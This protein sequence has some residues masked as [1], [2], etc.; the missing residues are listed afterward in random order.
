MT[1]RDAFLGALA[2]AS[3]LALAPNQNAAQRAHQPPRPQA[4]RVSGGVQAQITVLPLH[5]GHNSVDLLGTG[6]PGEIIVSRRGNGN[7]HGFSMVLFQVQTPAAYDS[8]SQPEWQVI[9]FFGGP[10]DGVTGKELFRTSEGADCTLGDLRVIRRGRAQPVEVVIAERDF[11]TS[12][13]DSAPVRFD[14]YALR[15]NTEPIG[16]KY[17]FQH[18][19]TVRAEGT[20]CDVDDAFDRELRLGYAGVLRWDGQR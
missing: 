1:K 15:A 11:G 16:P 10:H 20:Y 5:N 9:P 7:A 19:R 4:S 12:Y 3:V 2:S 18:L 6:Q 17:L 13:A 14:F 8:A